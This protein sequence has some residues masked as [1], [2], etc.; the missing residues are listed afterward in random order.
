MFRMAIL[1]KRKRCVFCE[2][3][4]PAPPSG[5]LSIRDLYGVL[6]TRHPADDLCTVSTVHF[7]D[8]VVQE[9]PVARSCCKSYALV[10][11]HTLSKLT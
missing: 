3:S 1:V 4:I 11:G 9:V 8:Q 5:D 2:T 6:Y 10:F 7:T